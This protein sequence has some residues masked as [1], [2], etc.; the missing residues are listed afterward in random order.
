MSDNVDMYYYDY[1]R[2]DYASLNH[3]ISHINWD[4]KFS[5]LFTTEEYWNIFLLHF[6]V[7]IELFVPLVRR[8]VIPLSNREVYP[9]HLRNMLN[10][11]EFLEKVARIYS[12]SRQTGLQRIQ[13]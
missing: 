1:K 2:A 5:F 3:Y 4:Y 9:R 7:A 11:K 6:T 12:H 13:Y 8:K 10:R